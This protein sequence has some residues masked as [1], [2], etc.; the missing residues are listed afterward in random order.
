MPARDIFH[1]QVK[2]A[3]SKEGWVITHDPYW[4]KLADS[5]MNVYEEIDSWIS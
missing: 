3:L 5:D 1:D 4:I 2:H